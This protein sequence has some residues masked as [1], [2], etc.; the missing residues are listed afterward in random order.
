MSNDILMGVLLG[1]V[2][3]CLVYYA[4]HQMAKKVKT[5]FFNPVLMSILV[6]VF[7]LLKIGVPYE[8]YNRGGQ[9]INFFLGPITVMFAIPIFK[10]MQV[11]KSNFIAIIAGVMTGVFSSLVSVLGLSKLFKVDHAFMLSLIPKSITTPMG[12]ATSET[13]GGIVSITIVAI[14]ISGITGNIIA[15]ILCD[16]LNITHPI[17]RGIAIG[18]SSHAMGTIKAF[19][20]GE[21]EGAMSSLSIGVTGLATVILI[22]LLM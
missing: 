12:V 15:P 10:Q 17:A 5:P 4:F 3:T 8:K 6:L 11:L 21:L 2:L 20:M 1:I 9:V 13:I 16:K 18:S 22:P 7:I 14:I 19:E